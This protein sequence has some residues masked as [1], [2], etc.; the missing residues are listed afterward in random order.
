MDT[1]SSTSLASGIHSM[2]INSNN[3]IQSNQGGWP[4]ILFGANMSFLLDNLP[5]QSQIDII[6][7][8][9]IKFYETK[10]PTMVESCITRHLRPYFC[11]SDHPGAIIMNNFLHL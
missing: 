9:V 6:F 4:G 8:N 10:S 7:S 3:D 11:N 5:Q 2:V 1:S